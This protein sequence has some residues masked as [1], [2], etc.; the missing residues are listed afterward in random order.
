MICVVQWLGQLTLVRKFGVRSPS[1]TAIYNSIKFSRSNAYGTILIYEIL[2][3][4]YGRIDTIAP[5]Y[6]LIFN[7]VYS[8][9][10]L[11]LID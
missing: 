9:I 11:F 8:I 10:L 3:R 2:L 5:N 1:F 7:Q 6:Y 4:Q